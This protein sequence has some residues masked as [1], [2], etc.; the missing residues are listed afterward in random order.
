[1]LMKGLWAGH[2]RVAGPCSLPP[3]CSIS[4]AEAGEPREAWPVGLW[5]SYHFQIEGF[6]ALGPLCHTLDEQLGQSKR[7]TQEFLTL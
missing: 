5:C 3:V 4:Y 1:M 7:T 2:G 6:P